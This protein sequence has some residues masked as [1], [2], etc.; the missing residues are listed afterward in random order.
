[1]P[2]SR[3]TDQLNRTRA[4]PLTTVINVVGVAWLAFGVATDH[5]GPAAVVLLA[6]AVGGWLWMTASMR[7]LVGP[8]HLEAACSLVALVGGALTGY[9][10]LGMVFPAVA[11][12]ILLLNRPFRQAPWIIL[13]GPAVMFPVTIANHRPLAAAIGG[14]TAVLGGAVMGILRREAQERVAQAA[15]LDVARAEADA[16]AARAE[17]LAGRNHLARELHDVLAHTLSA[18]SLQL[19]GLDALISRGGAPDPEVADQMDRIKRLVRDGLGEARG[20][21]AAL[22]EDLPP[23]DQRLAQLAAERNAA[24]EVA[25]RPR[26]LAPDVALALYRVAQEALTNAAKHAP[27]APAAVR[28]DYTG[29]E[30]ALDVTNPA[31]PGPAPL[32]DTSGGGYGLQGIRERILLI[33]GRVD[34]GPADGG[35]RVAARVP[36]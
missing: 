5:L 6:V 4:T 27:G 9:V 11:T 22:R 2:V 33:G 18:L 19:E 25:G 12:M 36:A 30:V 20:A 16:E 32:P 26:Q 21:V 28:L 31:P 10:T 17:L 29:Q 3:P 14:T 24:V 15:Q 35:W 1:M 8:G 23:L 13:L 34:A 7:G